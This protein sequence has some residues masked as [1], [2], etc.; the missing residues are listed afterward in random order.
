MG[1][2]VEADKDCRR[3]KPSLVVELLDKLEDP[4]ALHSRSSYQLDE[5]HQ[6][7]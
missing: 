6:E 7:V 4:L 2:E 1:R 5:H 3:V